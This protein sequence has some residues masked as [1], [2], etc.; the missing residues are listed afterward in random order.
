MID[1]ASAFGIYSYK[2]GDSGKP[3]DLGNGGLLEDYFLNFWKGPFLV[4]LTS[5]QTESDHSNDLILLARQVQ[6]NIPDSGSPPE[7]IKRLPETAIRNITYFK[8]NLGLM[9]IYQF[10]HEDIFHFTEG[11]HNGGTF[12]FSYQSVDEARKN[13]IHAVQKMKSGG[14]F[15]GWE[16][17][18]TGTLF[19][20][21]KEQAFL[22]KIDGEKIIIK[23]MDS[24][25]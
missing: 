21:K 2:I 7:I 10:H 17:G 12:L 19:K 25:Q 18:K 1:S 13:F 15:A 20:D 22:M 11:I 23:R 3:V 14:L 6:D 8:G 9:K 5:L 4:T 24:K 16:S